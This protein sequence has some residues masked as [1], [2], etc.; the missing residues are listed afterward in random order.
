MS[1]LTL[2]GLGI[3]RNGRAVLSG[4]DLRIAPGQF[5]GLL[6]LVRL[7]E[8]QR[9]PGVAVVLE[10]AHVLHDASILYVQTGDDAG[11]EHA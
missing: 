5:V 7:R 10:E 8:H 11:L 9:V 3:T 1:G 6:G 4:V 2:Q